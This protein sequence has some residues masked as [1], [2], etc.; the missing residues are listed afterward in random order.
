MSDEELQR[1]ITSLDDGTVLSNN[2][3]AVAELY[4]RFLDACP[5]GGVVPAEFHKRC[6]D[7]RSS[8]AESCP[9]RGCG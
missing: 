5:G 2:T 1:N 4:L 3:H 9:G 7:A 6:I 8:Y